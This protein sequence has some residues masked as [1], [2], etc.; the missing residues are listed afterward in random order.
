MFSSKKIAAAAGIL[1]GF[2]LIGVGAVQ[3]SAQGPGTCVQDSKGHVRCVQMSE[4]QVI[5]DKGGDVTVVNESTQ[6]CPS[7][8]SQVSCVDV[9]TAPAPRG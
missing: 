3:A 8:H 2:A 9:V 4:Y 5:K 7:A 1:G 6:T